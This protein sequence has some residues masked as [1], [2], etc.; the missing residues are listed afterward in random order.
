MNSDEKKEGG[1]LSGNGESKEIASM[2][3]EEALAYLDLPADA[4]K[5][6]IEN[7][8]WQLSKN[9]RTMRGDEAEQKL[10]DLSAVYDIATGN[11]DLREKAA[12]A[13]AK[14]KKFL[15]KTKAEWKNYVSYTWKYY[16]GALIAI[17]VSALLLYSFLFKPREDCGIISIGNFEC[18]GEYYDGILKDMGFKHPNVTTYNYV[19]ITEGDQTSDQ[20]N[21]QAAVAS[22][23]SGANVIVTDSSAMP[24][25]FEYLSD[26]TEL[27]KSLEKTL[28]AGIYGKVKP[29]YMSERE[30]KTMIIEYRKTKGIALSDTDID[31]S[32]LSDAKI[33]T[34]LMIDDPDLIKKLGYTNYWRNKPATAVFSI[35]VMSRDQDDS[36]AII[37]AVLKCL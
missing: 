19:A 13:R 8:F 37:T 31:V 21:N 9:L 20:F 22:V 35:S 29:V 5:D 1:I 30:Y 27:Y 3:R 26:C 12:E 14:E 16:V 6:A 4:D 17:I 32:T 28:P 7:K 24:Y 11:R 33:M 15:G 10:A 34:G 2:T 23:Y 18:S 25:F 36:A